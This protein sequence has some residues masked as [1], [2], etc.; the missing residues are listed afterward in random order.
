MKRI[1]LGSIIFLSLLSGCAHLDFGD[2]GLTFYEPKPY[3]FVTIKKDCV[4]TAT[5]LMIPGTKKAVKFKSG[6]GSANLSVNLKDGMVTTAGQITDTKIPET[7]TA[8][9]GLTTAATGMM[10]AA[11]KSPEGTA[12][13]ECSVKALLYPIESGV[14]GDKP[15][16]LKLSQ[17]SGQ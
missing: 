10:K 8:I 6:Y 11:V 12:P 9:A 2:E 16:D 5:V 17:F 3:L 7:I 15:I 13:T 1:T 4:C 14:V